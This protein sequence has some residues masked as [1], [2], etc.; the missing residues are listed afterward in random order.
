[1]LYVPNILHH[2]P[3]ICSGI[4]VC[5]QH[6]CQCHFQLNSYVLNIKSAK[7]DLHFSKGMLWIPI[8]DH[9][10]IPHF[11]SVIF[12]IRDA[13]SSTTFFVHNGTD[14]TISIHS[15][16]VYDKEIHIEC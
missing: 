16:Y 6:E 10:T 5:S 4:F 7:I 14:N 12:K 1:M 2:H 9:S 15:G 11:V 3:R 8:V 13:F